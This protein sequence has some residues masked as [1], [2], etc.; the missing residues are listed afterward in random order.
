MVAAIVLNPTAATAQCNTA[1]VAFDDTIY[2]TGDPLSIHVLA[3]DEDLDGDPLD[4]TV[5]DSTCSGTVTE[6]FGTVILTPDIHSSESCTIEYEI[7]DGREGMASAEITV[8]TTGLLFKDSFE[9]GGT[10]RWDD[11]EDGQ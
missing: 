10:T 3:N 8:I 9:T 7:S 1:P 11:V 6:D 4:V 5:G 2:H